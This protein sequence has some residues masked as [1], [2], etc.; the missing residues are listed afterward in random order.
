MEQLT[1]GSQLRKQS[2]L[3]GKGFING[4]WVNAQSGKTFEVRSV[5]HLHYMYQHLRYDKQIQRPVKS[6]EHV[7]SFRKQTLREQSKLHTRH[8]HLHNGRLENEHSC[9]ASGMN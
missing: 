7:Q 2:L 8:R 5:F 9:F 1:I 6:L 3:I 4:E